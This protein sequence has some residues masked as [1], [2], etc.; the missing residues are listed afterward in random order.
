MSTLTLIAF[1]AGCPPICIFRVKC[2]V[3]LRGVRLKVE[4][5]VPP[6]WIIINSWAI[7]LKF[8]RNIQSCLYIRLIFWPWFI[9]GIRQQT[10]DMKMPDL[11]SSILF[12]EVHSVGIYCP[13]VI[14]FLFIFWSL[15][16]PIPNVIN[17]SF[18]VC[19]PLATWITGVV[20]GCKCSL[21]LR[22][23]LSPPPVSTERNLTRASIPS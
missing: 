21:P 13:S 16:T 22:I 14:E 9:E 11:A 8:R 10:I 5:S 17:V 7:W 2:F 3:W 15:M 4:Y 6:I 19:P 20:I 18:A 23:S 12:Y 1:F